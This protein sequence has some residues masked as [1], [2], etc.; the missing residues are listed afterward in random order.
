MSKILVNKSSL[1]QFTPPLLIF[2]HKAKCKSLKSYICLVDGITTVGE[3]WKSVVF[4]SGCFF[5]FSRR[6]VERGGW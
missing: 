2:S 4:T 5:F 1:E 6:R 3:T